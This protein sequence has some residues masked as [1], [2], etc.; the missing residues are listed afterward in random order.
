MKENQ[1]RIIKI[2]KF[3]G[4]GLIIVT[5]GTIAIKQF[6]KHYSFGG[7]ATKSINK[8]FLFY[9][10][11]W[12]GKIKNN[13][14]IIFYLPKNTFY[15]KKGTIFTKYIRCI[16]GDTLNTKGL[17]Y[18]CNGKFIGKARTHDSKGR[19]IKNFVFNGVIPKG[20]YFA[21]GTHPKSYDSR[22]WG[23]VSKRDIIGV[24][25]WSY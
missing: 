3:I 1:K 14:I 7:V 12:E 25:L 22:Y 11:D 18:Y 17:N 24:T 21:M 19:S 15:Y 16:E 9:T 4:I 13:S 10:K 8:D 5:I 23:F 20:K 2:A 6:S